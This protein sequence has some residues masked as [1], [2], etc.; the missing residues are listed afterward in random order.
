MNVPD[1]DNL[2]H[3]IIGLAMHVHTRLGPTKTNIRRHEEWGDIP[4]Y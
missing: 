2:T 4:A 3:R 1:D